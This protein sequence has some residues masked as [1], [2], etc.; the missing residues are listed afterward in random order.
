MEMDNNIE[1]DMNVDVHIFWFSAVS[2]LVD[3][4]GL[5]KVVQ[6]WNFHSTPGIHLFDQGK[7]CCFAK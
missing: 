2:C 3:E 6:T 4:F 5:N 1:T 7:K